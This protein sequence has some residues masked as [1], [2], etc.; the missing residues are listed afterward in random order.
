MTFAKAPQDPA[1]ENVILSAAKKMK[2]T[3][4]M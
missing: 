2:N 1:A 3:K 4:E